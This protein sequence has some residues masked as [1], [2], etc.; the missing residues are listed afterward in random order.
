MYTQMIIVKKIFFVFPGSKYSVLFCCHII[1]Y[2]IEW[3]FIWLFYDIKLKSI[4]LIPY[5]ILLKNESCLTL[6]HRACAAVVEIG[7]STNHEKWN[8][9]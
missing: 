7:V 1:L 8:T 2:I 4:L 5:S 6:M 3:G 9:I